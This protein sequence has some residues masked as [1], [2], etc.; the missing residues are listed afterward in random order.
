MAC[1][2]F[3]PAELADYYRRAFDWETPLML[4][5]VPL[6][7]LMVWWLSRGFTHLKKRELPSGSTS[8]QTTGFQ[9]EGAHCRPLSP[10]GRFTP[11][12]YFDKVGD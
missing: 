1:G 11:L 12:G 10:F 4:A 5:G 6:A 8:R 2:P 3:V 7:A 9:P